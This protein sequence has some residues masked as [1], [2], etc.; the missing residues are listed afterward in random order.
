MSAISLY[1]YGVKDIPQESSCSEN[2]LSILHITVVH[3]SYFLDSSILFEDVL[4]E[5][6]SLMTVGTEDQIGGFI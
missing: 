5:I 3:I 1:L 2:N 6:C 4:N